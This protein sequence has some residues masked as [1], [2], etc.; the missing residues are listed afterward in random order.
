MQQVLRPYATTGVAIVGASLI[1]ATPVAAPSPAPHALREVALT[2]GTSSPLGEALAPWIAQYNEAADNA[3]VLLNN[4]FLAPHLDLQQIMVNMAN[5]TQQLLNDPANATAVTEQ[6]QENLKNVLTSYTLLNADTPVVNEAMKFTMS[7]D[8]HSL[9][10]G[11]L[12]GFLPSN[13]DAAEIKPILD[14]LA[15]PASG[16]MMGMIGPWLSPGIA[17]MN[18]IEAGDGL[19][20]I[21]ANTVGA[22]F[23]GATLNLDSLVPKINDAGLLPAGMN[24]DHLELAFGG[25]FTPGSVAVG[26]WD[27]FTGN[28]TPEASVPSVG[29]SIFN[30]LG[31]TINGVPL[32]N[33]IS[34]PGHGIGP[35][36]AVQSL[37]ELIGLQ[38]GSGWTGGKNGTPALPPGTGLHLPTIPDD[39]FSGDSTGAPTA[40][41]SQA[42]GADDFLAGL[43]GGS[44]EW[45]DLVNQLT[46]LLNGMP[47]GDAVAD[48]IN[49]MF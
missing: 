11:Q 28:S 19:N 6:M 20:T 36:G 29:G 32:L 46:D 10:F 17:L 2:T 15:S 30:S 9:L 37:H 43:S 4:H 39:F 45:T 7:G 12:P 21:F 35:I 3:S 33:S 23:N 25:L 44:A 27:L 47:G 40:A 31:L 38:L 34:M 41:A 49:G 13:I 26:P 24:F 8:S 18:S 1:A 5:F 22:I 48:L 14:F 16:V 42:F